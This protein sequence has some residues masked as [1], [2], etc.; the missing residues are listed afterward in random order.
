MRSDYEYLNG[1]PVRTETGLLGAPLT[2]LLSECVRWV[3]L[4]SLCFLS[5]AQFCYEFSVGAAVPF[6]R[7][8]GVSQGCFTPW[9]CPCFEVE[10]HHIQKFVSVVQKNLL[11]VSAPCGVL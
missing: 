6:F 2:F 5:A 3:V 4:V 7:F 10:F 8:D 11:P 1:L 9:V